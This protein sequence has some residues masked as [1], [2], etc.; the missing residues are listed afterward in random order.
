MCIRDSHLFLAVTKSRIDAQ[1][2]RSDLL[3]VYTHGKVG[4]VGEQGEI[5]GVTVVDMGRVGQ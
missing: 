4:V 3:N 5:T 2:L 1:Q